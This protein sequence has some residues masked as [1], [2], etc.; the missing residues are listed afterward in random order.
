[1]DESVRQLQWGFSIC[2]Y[3]TDVNVLYYTAFVS[4]PTSVNATL[5]STAT[6]N[7]SVT[8]GTIDWLVNGSPL[9]ELRTAYIKVSS[10]ERTSFLK[11]PATVEYNNTVVVCEVTIV[12]TILR[13]DSAVLIVQGMLYKLVNRQLIIYI[14][15]CSEITDA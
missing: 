15:G 7:C 13:S 4:T 12:D 14:L 2:R 1:M 5:G 9:S 10:N 6:F 3:I 11:V 8:T